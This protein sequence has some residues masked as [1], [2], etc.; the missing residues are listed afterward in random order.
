VT[1]SAEAAPPTIRLDREDATAL[2]FEA[3]VV[4]H[5]RLGDRPT[6]VLDRSAFY[7][8]S[9]GQMADRGRLGDVEVV[10][11]QLDAR[12]VVHHVVDGPPPPVGATVLGEVDRERR[13]T[14]MA[15]HTGQHVLSR[16]LVEAA[17]A[18]TVSARLG[19]TACTLDV[20]RADVS[21][22][23]VA[24]AEALANAVIDDDLPVRAWL[25]TPGELGALALRRAPKRTEGVRVVA[26]GDFD[27]TP[28]GGTHVRSSAAIGLVRVWSVERHKGGLR[29]TFDAGPRARGALF[30]ESRLVADLARTLTCGAVEIPRALERLR[31]DLAE[32]RTR[33][34]RLA[35]RLYEAEADR[36][37][38]EADAAGRA[39][40]VATLDALGA[41][42][43]A[44]LEQARAV[45][46]R[47]AERPGALAVVAV[48]SG[49]ALVTCVARGPGAPVDC[50]RLLRAL[51]TAGGGR[52]GG[53]PDRAEGRLPAAV[54]LD[55]LLAAALSSGAPEG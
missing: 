41:G 53:R 22:R 23:A 28:C 37:S 5:G 51:A 32:A 1:T 20:D 44:A 8:E 26:I 31:K 40:V 12:E 11:A 3:R 6:V 16:A 2:S 54:D 33:A 48:R 13:R 14:F 50:G 27:V 7:P 15:L 42:D 4:A 47:L 19:E 35:H 46:G 24:E 52:G 29:L 30:G 25:P 36:L 39:I 55:A 38:R 34:G 18:E 49:E 9:G 21:E 45:S 10:D 17:G 43:A